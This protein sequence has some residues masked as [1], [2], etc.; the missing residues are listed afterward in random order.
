MDGPA[1]DTIRNGPELWL[2]IGER[3]RAI[4]GRSDFSVFCILYRVLRTSSLIQ[5][6]HAQTNVNLQSALPIVA[7]CII[8]Y[9]SRLC[10]EWRL[11]IRLAF[12]TASRGKYANPDGYMIIRWKEEP[13]GS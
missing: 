6:A 3:E 1:T 2:L 8:P 12:E 4:C 5:R 13:L 9:V 11:A 7:L 10:R